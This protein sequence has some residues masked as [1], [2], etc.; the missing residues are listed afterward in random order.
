MSQ[1]DLSEQ[2]VTDNMF[3]AAI[4]RILKTKGQI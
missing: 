1:D 4:S 2:Q 3:I